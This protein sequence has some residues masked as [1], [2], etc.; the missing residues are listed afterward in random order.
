M[1]SK[2]Q[3]VQSGLLPLEAH[4]VELS[5]EADT[6]SAQSKSR[7]VYS[8]NDDHSSARALAYVRDGCK[9]GQGNRMDLLH[10]SLSFASS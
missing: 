1:A 6:V 2:V 4:E 10:G 9:T 7:T 3:I 8:D 5:G